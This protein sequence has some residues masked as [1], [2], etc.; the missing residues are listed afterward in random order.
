MNLIKKDFSKTGVYCFR[1]ET[2]KIL[3]MLKQWAQCLTLIVALVGQK[4]DRF[5]RLAVKSCC[6]EIHTVR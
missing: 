1:D 4:T 5:G 6:L 3:F 2:T